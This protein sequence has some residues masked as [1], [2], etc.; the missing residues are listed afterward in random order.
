MRELR[1]A[2]PPVVYNYVRIC[3]SMKEIQNTLKE[4]LQGSEKTK[5]NSMKHCW[6]ELKEFKQKEGESI[7][8]ITIA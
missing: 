1:Y 2:L 4:K 7:D 8:F 3:K 6:V 5:I